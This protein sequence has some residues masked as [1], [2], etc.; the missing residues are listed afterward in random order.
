MMFLFSILA[1][2]AIGI[3]TCVLVGTI[4]YD[5]FEPIEDTQA[6]KDECGELLLWLRII[7]GATIAYMSMGVYAY[8]MTGIG[9]GSMTNVVT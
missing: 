1:T 3:T 6:F 4:D 2:Y 7:H 8:I 9:M 5:A